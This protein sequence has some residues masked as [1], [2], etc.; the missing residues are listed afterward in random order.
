MPGLILSGSLQN[1]A[2][3]HYFVS[4]LVCLTAGN[5]GTAAVMLYTPWKFVVRVSVDNVFTVVI[6]PVNGLNKQQIATIFTVANDCALR[7]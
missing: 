7:H 3:L 5:T 4:Q 2:L 6:S 1:A